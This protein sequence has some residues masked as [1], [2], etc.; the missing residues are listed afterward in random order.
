[1]RI[2]TAQENESW[3]VQDKRSTSD[4]RWAVCCGAVNQP[5]ACPEPASSQALAIFITQPYSP[6]ARSH[7]Q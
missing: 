6:Q 2:E 1:M 4:W 5:K 7:L 3:K